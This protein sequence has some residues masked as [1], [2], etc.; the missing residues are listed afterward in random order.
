MSDIEKLRAFANQIM[1][2]WPEGDVDGGFLQ[3]AAEACGLIEPTQMAAPCGVNCQCAEIA[4][5]PTTCYR[6]TRLLTGE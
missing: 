6:K 3:D 1:S 5:F 4:D 2:C